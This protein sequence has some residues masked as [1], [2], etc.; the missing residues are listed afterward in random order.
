MARKSARLS[1]TWYSVPALGV[2]F[3]LPPKAEEENLKVAPET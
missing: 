2:G 3:I 1:L